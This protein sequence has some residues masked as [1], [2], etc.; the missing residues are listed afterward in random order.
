MSLASAKAS[1]LLA[2]SS[3]I[4]ATESRDHPN[5]SIVVLWPKA[6]L[7]LL[8]EI[9]SE[10]ISIKRLARRDAVIMPASEKSISFSVCEG[11]ME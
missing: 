8:M 7:F 4:S 1:R 6:A 3:T 10:S 11:V 9:K 2:I 5:I